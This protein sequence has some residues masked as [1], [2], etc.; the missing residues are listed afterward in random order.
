MFFAYFLSGLYI[1]LM[2][3]YTRSCSFSVKEIGKYLHAVVLLACDGGGCLQSAALRPLFPD[4]DAASC[5]MPLTV[6]AAR[7][8]AH[9]KEMNNCRIRPSAARGRPSVLLTVADGQFDV[10]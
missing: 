3:D 9:G 2:V 4:Q 5:S 1:H 8:H 7:L 6:T 10:Q